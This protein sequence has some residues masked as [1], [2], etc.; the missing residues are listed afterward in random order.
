LPWEAATLARPETEAQVIDLLHSLAPHWLSC[1]PCPRWEGSGGQAVHGSELGWD[2]T[3]RARTPEKASGVGNKLEVPKRESVD[4]PAGTV[5]ELER[6]EQSVDFFKILDIC[7]LA[8]PLQNYFAHRH[9][10][11]FTFLSV[12]FFFLQLAQMCLAHILC[13]TLGTNCFT[14]LNNPAWTISH[15][16]LTN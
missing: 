13:S 12:Y 5:A 11:F 14:A 10:F 3:G 16:V 15:L 9:L 4:G 8:L 2:S 6:A 7:S 1:K